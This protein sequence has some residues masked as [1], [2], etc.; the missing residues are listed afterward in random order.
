MKKLA[1]I[2]GMTLGMVIN[3]SVFIGAVYL[4]FV[5]L[6]KLGFM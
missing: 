1:Y 5:L 3:V 4:S 6:S 2:V